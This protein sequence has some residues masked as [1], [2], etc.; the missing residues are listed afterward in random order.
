MTGCARPP[1]V[2]RLRRSDRLM[3]AQD[4]RVLLE[5]AEVGTLAA[6]LP[7]GRPYCVPVNF[8]M[9]DGKIVVHSAMEG[10]KVD[11]I[12]LHADVCFTVF[13][14]GGAV[15]AARACDASYRY[16]SVVV[17]GAAHAIEDVHRKM[18]AL[19]AL[20]RKYAPSATG[21]VST[22]AAENTLVLE[23]SMDIVTGKRSGG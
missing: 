23:I 18:I 1:A 9:L 12:R 21:T 13:E 5:K 20:T 7:D 11:A 4:V 22:A 6:V 16:R 10:L 19:E 14:A 8:A 15:P 3:D 17:F 2:G